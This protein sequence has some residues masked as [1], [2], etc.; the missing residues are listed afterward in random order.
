MKKLTKK[1]KYLLKV[2]LITSGVSIFMIFLVI[3]ILRGVFSGKEVTRKPAI[4]YAAIQVDRP[5]MQE[6]YLTE[7]ENSRPG[8]LLEKVRGVVVHYTANP[9]TDA[10]ANRN[11][12]ESRKDEPVEQ[13]NKVSSHF[14]IGLD[15]TILCCVPENEIAYASN[16]RNGDTLSIECC[17]PDKTGKFTQATYESLVHLVAYLS[18]KYELEQEGIIRHYDVTGK[19]CPRYMVVHPDAWK[20]FKKDIVTY[21][22]KGTEV[23]ALF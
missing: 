21:L 12:F 7:N 16:D 15:G 6:A 4:D 13:Q 14:I 23:S 9:G 20:E 1:K 11:Y 2:V 22:K 18:D 19:K 3:G 5:E 10:M 8:T 17:H